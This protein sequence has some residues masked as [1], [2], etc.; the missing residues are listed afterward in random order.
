MPSNREN[1]V[2][3][4]T[5]E[6]YTAEQVEGEGATSVVHRVRDS[7]GDLWA[8]KCLKPEQATST[9]TKR[10]LNELH[11]CQNLTHRNIIRVVDHGFVMQGNKKCPFFVMPL[12]A[13]T[14]RKIMTSSINP[15]LIPYYFSKLLDGV[16]AAHLMGV[17]HRDLKP[18]NVL[19]DPSADELIVSD[20]GIAH[21][22][23]EAMITTVETRPQERLA[24][25]QYAAPEQRVSGGN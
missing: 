24:N 25:F 1:L 2:F 10:F 21:F 3:N 13:S 11:F 15:N 7:A 14:L 17:W 23:A 22:Q 16:E 12:F 18:E 9:R 19:H 6:V 8:L 4:T 5:A 20:F